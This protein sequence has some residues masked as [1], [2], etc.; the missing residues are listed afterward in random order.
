[1]AL[2]VGALFPTTVSTKLED[3]VLV[4]S[5]TV[6]VM[7]DVP[8]SPS[9]GVIVTVL[10]APVP[11]NEIFATGTR[12]TLEDVAV[13]SKLFNGVSASPIVKAIGSL[14]VLSAVDCGPMAEI[15]GD[16]F[17]VTVS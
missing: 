17:A 2:I 12:L 5:L 16:W 14:A 3:A 10:A 6:I 13:S 11:A 9:T 7:V 8:L 1:M 4:P 15:V